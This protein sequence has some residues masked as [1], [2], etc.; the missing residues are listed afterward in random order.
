MKN[1]EVIIIGA[2][3]AGSSAAK[4]LTDA[5]KDVIIFDK[6]IFPRLKPCGG[7]IQ[8][9]LLKQMNINMEDYPFQINKL[10]KMY[11]HKGSLNYTLKIDQYSIIRTEFD[12]WLLKRSNAPL[13]TENI[14]DIKLENDKFILND[15]Y[16][17]RY[18]IGAGGTACP[19]ARKF[20]KT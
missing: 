5:G 7:W 10:N 18:L 14:I 2:G 19:V 13:K 15:T 12:D 11:I 3:P 20:F 8:P 9:S 1:F 17:C 6:K 4:I 16:S